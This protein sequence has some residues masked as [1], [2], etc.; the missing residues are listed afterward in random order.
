MP[1]LADDLRAAPQ[2]IVKRLEPGDERRWDDFVADAPQATIFHRSAWRDIIEQ[3]LGHRCHYL[4]VERN[5]VITGILP[6]AEIRSRLFGHALIS[7]PFCVYGG[8]VTSDPDSE[9]QLLQSAKVLADDL[10]VDYLELR[11]RELRSPA[12]PVKDLYVSFRKVIHPDHDANMKAIPRKQRAM[13]RKGIRADL[14]AQHGGSIDEFYRVYAESVR[15]LGTPVLSRNYYMRLQQTF[16]DDCEVTVVTHEG[17]PV[18]AV[19]SFYFRDEVHPYYGGSV[20]RGRDL[21]ANDFMYWA[22]MQRATERGARVFDFGRSKQGTGAH[23]FKKH[24]G[25]EPKPLPYAY[26]LVRASEIPNISPTNRKYSLF[27]KAWQKLPV[28]V[29]CLLGPWLA[30][31]L[32]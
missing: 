2:C 10:R 25:F 3:V 22:L 23:D 7:T 12:W 26:H 8:V 29:S 17:Q 28:P 9:V 1:D 32:G 6:L 16:G 19:M 24:W 14:Q 31:D 27:I 21:A 5:G 15:N 11:N 13:V 20:A 30:R 18:S 4:Y